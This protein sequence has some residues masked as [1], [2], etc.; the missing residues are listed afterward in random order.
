MKIINPG[1]I[2]LLPRI[3]ILPLVI[4]LKNTSQKIGYLGR[5][6]ILTIKIVSQDL[7]PNMKEK[8]ELVECVQVL[9]K[10]R[11]TFNNQFQ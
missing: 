1:K 5:F 3:L 2:T 7:W 10:K 11:K 4:S 8:E 6:I 9:L